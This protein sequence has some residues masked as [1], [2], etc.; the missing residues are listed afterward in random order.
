M[1]YILD[2]ECS[3]YTTPHPLVGG[4]GYAGSRIAYQKLCML[5]QFHAKG[6]LPFSTPS[7]QSSYTPHLLLHLQT[8]WCT[9]TCMLS[10][11][12]TRLP[13]PRTTKLATTPY[14]HTTIILY[15]LRQATSNSSSYPTRSS[16]ARPTAAPAPAYHPP[17]P[18]PPLH[19]R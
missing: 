18:V 7:N 17:G 16:L 4:G 14:R 12:A 2:T 3:G 5:K 9:T 19:H 8:A 10:R 6:N 11:H 1:Y 13:L 15:R